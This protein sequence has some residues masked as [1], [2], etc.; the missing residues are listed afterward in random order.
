MTR[1]SGSEGDVVVNTEFKHYVAA[2]QQARDGKTARGQGRLDRRETARARRP[3]TFRATAGLSRRFASPFWILCVA[4]F[5]RVPLACQDQPQSARLPVARHAPADEPTPESGLQQTA[6]GSSTL[7]ALPLSHKAPTAPRTWPTCTFVGSADIDGNGNDDILCWNDGRLSFWNQGEEGPYET[8]LPPTSLEKTIAGVPNAMTAADIDRDGR[9]DVL[10]AYGI[11]KQQRDVPVHL[12]ALRVKG[13]SGD[14]RRV[15]NSLYQ[16]TSYRPQVV[17][18]SLAD[19]EGDSRPEILIAHHD[20]KYYV[21]AH[22]LRLGAGNDPLAGPLEARRVA[23]IRMASSWAAGRLPGHKKSSLFVGRPYGEKKLDPGDLFMLDGQHRVHISTKLGVRS[24]AFGDG[25]GD[26]I[27]DV[28]FGDGWHYD[29]GAKA[30]GRLSIATIEPQGWSTHLIQSTPG[31]YEIR[32]IRIT[33][34]DFDRKPE[35]VAAGNRYI[36]LFW[37][38]PDGWMTRKLANGNDF[39]LATIG[40]IRYLVIPGSPI[41][42]IPVDGGRRDGTPV[43]WTHRTPAP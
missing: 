22:L 15:T 10:I 17:A 26:G 7:P 2:G 24:V 43:S 29:Y 11:G 27:P 33:D 9:D 41:R 37:H 28:L 5:A 30:S 4:W 20:S 21:T 35:I 31:Q 32:K 34:V 25:D 13:P 19:L 6:L 14:H 39:E 36:S 1:W 8:F 23:R 18:L 38:S 40:G 12:V 3:H 16:A 42:V